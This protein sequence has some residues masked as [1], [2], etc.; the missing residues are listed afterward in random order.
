MTISLD[1][2]LK[3]L[4]SLFLLYD[5]LRVVE[6]YGN[7]A[8]DHL[9]SPH[10]KGFF[11]KKEVRKELLRWNKNIFKHHLKQ[12]FSIKQ[13]THIF[14]ERWESDF[15]IAA[16]LLQ[17][18]VKIVCIVLCISSSDSNCPVMFEFHCNGSGE[19][20]SASRYWIPITL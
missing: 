18:L 6:I 2:W 16:N 7:Y 5:K 13:T 19:S 9:L 1:Q 14:F 3:V 8:V 10:I 20:L 15:F 17:N 11:K 12:G 4:Y